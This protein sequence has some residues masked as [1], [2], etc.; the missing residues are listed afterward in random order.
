MGFE[1]SAQTLIDLHGIQPWSAR[2]LVRENL[3]RQVE[4]ADNSP[5]RSIHVEQ[6]LEYMGEKI[7]RNTWFR[8]QLNRQQF[9]KTALD[10]MHSRR[11]N[12]TDRDRQLL[13]EIFDSMDFDKNGTL[14]LGEWAGGLSVFFQGTQEECIHAVFNALDTNKNKTLSK[15]ELQEYLKPFV[16]AMSPAEADSLRPL[17]VKK[18][19][20]EIFN[21]MDFNH[22][23]K[24]T[25]DELLDWSR[26]GNTIIEKMADIIDKEVYRIWLKSHHGEVYGHDERGVRG[27]PFDQAPYGGSPYGGG[28]DF[29]D[30]RVRDEGQ[31]RGAPNQRY[32]NPP[33]RGGQ[34]DSH[35]DRF[36]LSGGPGRGGHYQDPYHEQDEGGMMGSLTSWLTGGTNKQ[37][38]RYMDQRGGRYPDSYGSDPRD[39]HGPRKDIPSNYP[40]SNYRDQPPRGGYGGGGGSSP[41]YGDRYGPGTSGGNAYDAYGGRGGRYP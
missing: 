17:L 6:G 19:T 22:D 9:V 15:S 35:Y 27:Q 38:P 29:D 32:G 1:K 14:D 39:F 5:L 33:G 12:H 28:R 21:E 37:D 26:R 4:L 2:A 7:S 16:K 3:R 23:K 18:A 41:T 34:P 11:I 13:H 8:S 10:L 31:Y 20:D 40:Q 24:I 36:G 25:S 30:R